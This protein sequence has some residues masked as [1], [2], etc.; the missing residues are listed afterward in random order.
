MDKIY[1]IDDILFKIGNLRDQKNLSQRKIS[2]QLN[3]GESYINQIE[4][5]RTKLS[6]ETF[7][8]ILS[9]MDVTPEQFF[10]HN[11][12]EYEKDMTLIELISGLSEKDKDFAIE[13]I[14]KIK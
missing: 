2:E 14:K 3:H 7:L 12:K 9:I 4:N 6:M 11:E 5:K 10:Y 8:Q 13:I 1:D